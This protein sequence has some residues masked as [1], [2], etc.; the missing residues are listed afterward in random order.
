MKYLDLINGKEDNTTLETCPLVPKKVIEY[1]KSNP[2]ID[3]YHVSGGVKLIINGYI[4]I[5]KSRYTFLVDKPNGGFEL[6]EE[7]YRY[8]IILKDKQYTLHRSEDEFKEIEEIFDGFY[9]VWK[10]ENKTFSEW[11]K[12]YY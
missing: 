6:V 5:M 12:E 10:K 11:V 2:E 1:F 3:N 4:A 7:G 8:R 9:K